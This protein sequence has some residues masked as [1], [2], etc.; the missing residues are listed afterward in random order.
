M[1]AVVV[2]ESGRVVLQQRRDNGRWALPSGAVEHGET[3][4]QAVV[5]EIEEET[6]CSVEIVRITGVY[7]DPE[8]TT[9]SYPNGDVVHYVSV[10]FECRFVGGHVSLD[11]GIGGREMVRTRP[12]AGRCLGSA[13]GPPAARIRA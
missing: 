8:Q 3:I 4:V 6:G 5:R 7:S 10:C 2:D 12:S 11:R 9:I 13:S 1:C